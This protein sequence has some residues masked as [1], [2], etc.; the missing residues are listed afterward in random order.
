[1]I[2][3]SGFP[4]AFLDAGIRSSARRR[5]TLQLFAQNSEPG[6]RRHQLLNC[7]DVGTPFFVHARSNWLDS[8]AVRELAVAVKAVRSCKMLQALSFGSSFVHDDEE[9]L[10]SKIECLRFSH[11]KQ[12]G[13]FFGRHDVCALL[14]HV[15]QLDR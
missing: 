8:N 5:F 13:Q 7:N 9:S 1:M 15:C 3:E 12:M 6:V 4:S 2:P 14:A 10:N 11:Q